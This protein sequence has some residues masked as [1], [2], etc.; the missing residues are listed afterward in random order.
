MH[1][2]LQMQ[3]L[4]IK[5][6]RC[7]KQ[8]SFLF[9]FIAIPH[10][11]LD[12]TVCVALGGVIAL[13]VQLFTAAKTDLDLDVRSAEIQRQRDQRKSLLRNKAVQLHDLTLVHEQLFVAQRIL[14]KDIPLLIRADVHALDKDLT[15]LDVTVRILQIHSAIANA[16]DLCT[17]QSDTCLVFLV[18]KVFVPRL[19]IL[20]YNFY[21]LGDFKR[22]YNIAFFL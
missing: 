4:S 17:V 9:C 22:G 7:Q 14:V 15:V 21:I 16:L 19:F 1:L 3:C 20:G 8:R 10:T 18:H 12:H 5:K 2:C 6:D 11:T 13:V